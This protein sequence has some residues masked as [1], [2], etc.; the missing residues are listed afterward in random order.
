MFIIYL[1]P[2]LSILYFLYIR[3]TS[4]LSKLPGPFYT[5]LTP[6]YLIYQEFSGNRRTY[7]D[8]L[9]ASYGP[10]IRISPNECSFSSYSA[11][12]QIYTSGGSG[13]DRTEF[14]ELFRQFGTKTLFSMPP[15]EE[16]SQRKR[17]LADR[18]ANSNILRVETVEALKGRAKRFLENCLKE[19]GGDADVYVH[20][21]CFALDGASQ[22]LFAPYGTNSLSDPEDFKIMQEMSYADSLRAPYLEYYA[23][24]L[25]EFFDNLNSK[26]SRSVPLANDFVLEAVQKPNPASYS[27]LSKLHSKASELEDLSA[28]AECMDHLAAGIDTTGDGLCFLMHE[29]SLPQNAHIQQRLRDE[30]NNSQDKSFDQL[31][32]LDAVVKEGLR[33]FPPIPMSFPRYTPDSGTTLDGYYIP[34]HVIVSCQPF[35]LHKDPEVFPL[36]E[37][38]DPQR[39]LEEKGELERNRMFF[40]FS[41]G[42]RGCIGKHLALAE[43]KILLREVYGEYKTVLGKEKADMRFDDQVISSR[44]KGQK[45]RLQFQKVV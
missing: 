17:I 6:L 35:T 38:F 24:R 42:A 27:L 34:G 41:Q 15:R 7:I 11:M 21:H 3:L 43:M 14:Y 25:A 31:P 28:A 39:W 8:S 5:K 2:I 4:P 18:Y 12:K 45:C 13:F 16:H 20:L 9:H 10:V 29:L 36:P 44:P 26:R 22:H 30:I 40:A 1:L 32:Y 19:D 37:K 23:P 33:V